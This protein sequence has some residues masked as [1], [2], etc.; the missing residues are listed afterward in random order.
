MCIC[1]WEIE[2][3][4]VVK[5]AYLHTLWVKYWLSLLKLILKDCFY[6]GTFHFIS[7]WLL[8]YSDGSRKTWKARHV[9]DCSWSVNLEVIWCE[10]SEKWCSLH[11][12][13]SVFFSSHSKVAVIMER[14][15][16]P[17]FCFPYLTLP[18]PMSR[19]RNWHWYIITNWTPHHV[20]SSPGFPWVCLF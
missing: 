7:H 18:W 12:K 5:R 14:L 10:C 8:I 13:M 2:S 11:S 4:Y 1:V 20:V 16:M 3:V 19:L 9:I 6:H 17:N 15:P